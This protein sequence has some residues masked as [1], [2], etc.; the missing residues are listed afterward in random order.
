M[1]WLNDVAEQ[2]FGWMWPM[3]WQVNLLI[4]ILWLADA[5]LRRWAAPDDLFT[6]PADC[7][8]VERLAE[9]R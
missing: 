1:T 2:W 9:F 6:P 4:V 7:D 5:G 3:F 8:R